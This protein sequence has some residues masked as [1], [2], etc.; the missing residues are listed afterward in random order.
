MSAP[1]L[2]CCISW[3]K[4]Q[5]SQKTRPAGT[6]AP[7]SHTIR[8]SKFNPHTAPE[9]IL[10]PRLRIRF[11]DFPY[12]HYSI[13]QRLLTLE[14]CCGLGTAAS[15]CINSTPFHGPP[16][17]TGFRKGTLPCTFQFRSLMDFHW[18]IHVK[19]KR[20]LFPIPQQASGLH[21]NVTVLKKRAGR[22]GTSSCF[23]FAIVTV[24]SESQAFPGPRLE[25]PHPW[26]FAL[27]TEPSSTSV[28]NLPHVN[29]RYFHQDLHQRLLQAGS[30]QL[31]YATAASIYWLLQKQQPVRIGST[32]E[33][34][35]F[36]GL[37]DSAGE[38]L[39]TP[40][41][42]PTSMATVLLSRSTNTFLIIS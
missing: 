5:G 40:W 37:V 2:D 22:A 41:R 32:L 38:L 24:N 31:F 12:L 26:R 36:S 23:S 9:P 15:S 25:P 1:V 10:F 42:V 21:F 14:T 11:A 3:F 29:H 27:P 30:R 35:P 28:F 7:T 18:P 34:H 17:K 8:L 20:N 19:K 4:K 39:H 33:R 6:C 16:A 13:N